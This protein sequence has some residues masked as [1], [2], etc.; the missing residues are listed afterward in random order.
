[1]KVVMREFGA[2]IEQASN[3]PQD[4]VRW[5]VALA[6]HRAYQKLLRELGVQVATLPPLAD[7]ANG[8]FVQD[9]VV[10]LPELVIWTRPGKESRREEVA[11]MQKDFMQYPSSIRAEGFGIEKPGT[12]DGGDVIVVDKTIFIAETMRTSKVAIEQLRKSLPDGYRL[13][14]IP[15]L[16]L[17]QCLH[18]RTGCSHLGNNTFLINPD[19]IGGPALMKEGYKILEVDSFEPMA[20]NTRLIGETVIGSS[21]YPKTNAKLRAAGLN[22]REVDLSEIAKAGGGASCVT[23][24]KL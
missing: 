12:L 3:S 10:I 8:V 21:A 22:V 16:Q 14:E 18:F 7:Q 24:V 4:P 5:E 19:W 11:A 9:T 17:T 15:V 1:M 2:E 23:L 13:V 20:A 6:Q